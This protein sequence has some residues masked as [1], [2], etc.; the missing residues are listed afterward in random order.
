MR[1]AGGVAISFF[2]LP[3]VYLGLQFLWADLRIRLGLP[4]YVVHGYLAGGAVWL[5]W[6]LLIL[7]LGVTAIL[8]RK[9][10]I[11][12]LILGIMLLIG[13]AIA[14]PSTLLPGY[15]GRAGQRDVQAT[16]Q[17]ISVSQSAWARKTGR[18]PATQAELDQS[19][20]SAAEQEGE[21]VTRYARDGQRL[22]YRLIYIA[23]ATGPHLP[24]PAGDQ[25]GIIYCAVSSDQNRFWITGTALREAVG[26]EVVLLPSFEQAGPWVEEGRLDR[27][28]APPRK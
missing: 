23:G 3:V 9:G 26:R 4:F 17:R 10:S 6:G 8:R 24:S 20:R 25:P 2:S 1:F 12:A 14:I 19:L 22:P 27:P 13:A 5:V 7:G 16:M 11:L 28:A 21:L 18:F 15:L